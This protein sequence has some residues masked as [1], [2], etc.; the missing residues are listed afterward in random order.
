MSGP[1]P[2]PMSAII[3]FLETIR[4]FE[5]NALVP[6]RYLLWTRQRTSPLKWSYL[7][8]FDVELRRSKLTVGTVVG[9]SGTPLNR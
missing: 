3:A 7:F 5:R 8:P 2:I 6:R 9:S 1:I 4:G